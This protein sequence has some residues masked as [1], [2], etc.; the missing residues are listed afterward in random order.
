MT[1]TVQFSSRVLLSNAG[2]D[3]TRHKSEAE[4][5]MIPLLPL[6]DSLTILCENL[7][8][9]NYVIQRRNIERILS[10]RDNGE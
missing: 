6:F 4:G 9:L 1:Q 10:Q 7:T 8:K 2:K 5:G 3:L